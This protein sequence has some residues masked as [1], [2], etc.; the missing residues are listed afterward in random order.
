MNPIHLCVLGASAVHA[1]VFSP[2]RNKGRQE[3]ESTNPWHSG[4]FSFIERTA[5]PYPPVSSRPPKT[6]GLRPS[7]GGVPSHFKG[8]AISPSR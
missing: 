4:A 6:G 2:L 1:Q 7:F 5:W 3:S 8:V